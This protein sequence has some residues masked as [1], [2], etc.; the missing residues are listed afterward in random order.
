MSLVAVPPAAPVP[1]TPDAIPGDTWYPPLSIA[2]FKSAQRVPSVVTDG[3][4]RE[5]LLGGLLSADAELS[6]WRAA[7]EDAGV[8]SLAEAVVRDTAGRVQSSV[9]GE[10]RAVALW[11][12]AVYAYAAAD[13][14]DTHNDIS[15]TAEGRP[16]AE[17][18]ASRAPEL[19]RTATSAIRDMLGRPRNRSRLL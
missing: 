16:R 15:A 2:D 3:R 17:E 8:A 13:L 6:H 19:L 5:A 11:R 12:R 1:V 14:A 4:A 7:Q 10:P 18:R 9:G